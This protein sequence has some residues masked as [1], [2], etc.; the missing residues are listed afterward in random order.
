M[1]RGRLGPACERAVADGGGVDRDDDALRSE[2]SKRA[3]STGLAMA[4][5]EKAAPLVL[6]HRSDH[7]EDGRRT[8][9][10]GYGGSSALGGEEE[11]GEVQKDGVLT[12]RASRCS[13]EAEE[14]E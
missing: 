3:H 7:D 9:D 12:L 11:G 4:N 14:G 10:G 5:Q 6:G 8:A 1:T 13:S 2:A